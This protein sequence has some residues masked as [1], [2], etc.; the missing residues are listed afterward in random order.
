MIAGRVYFGPVLAQLTEAVRGYFVDQRTLEPASFKALTGQ[1]R[2]TAI[3][4]LEWLDA[5]GV[6][7]RVG[8]ARIKG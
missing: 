5:H 2:R 7:R 3:P 6:T 8:D 4:L 1:S